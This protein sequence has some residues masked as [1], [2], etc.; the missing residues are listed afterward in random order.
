MD[1]LLEPNKVISLTSKHLILKTSKLIKSNH[2][3]SCSFSR[4][5]GLLWSWNSYASSADRM[6][7]SSSPSII[8]S[9]FSCKRNTTLLKAS[10]YHVFVLWHFGPSCADPLCDENSYWTIIGSSHQAFFL[11]RTCICRSHAYCFFCLENNK[12]FHSWFPIC[13]NC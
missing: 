7:Q 4:L 2:I 5:D 13:K 6:S 8:R 11:N 1:F 3:S 10:I 12:T 9:A